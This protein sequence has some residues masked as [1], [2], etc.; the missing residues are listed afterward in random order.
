MGLQTNSVNSDYALHFCFL[1]SGFWFY[2]CFHT[3]CVSPIAFIM[4]G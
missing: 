2:F 1:L 4:A 3:F